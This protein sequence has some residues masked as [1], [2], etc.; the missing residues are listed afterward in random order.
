MDNNGSNFMKKSSEAPENTK[1]NEVDEYD[2][3]SIFLATKLQNMNPE[4]QILAQQLIDKVCDKGLQ[5]ELH[6]YN[7]IGNITNNQQTPQL[8]NDH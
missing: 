6:E 7:D 3:L 8:P 4:Q 2:A 1:N 5:G